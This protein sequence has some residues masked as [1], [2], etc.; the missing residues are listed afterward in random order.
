LT[1]IQLN[2]FF[3]HTFER[4]SVKKYTHKKRSQLMIVIPKCQLLWWVSKVS[5]TIYSWIEQSGYITNSET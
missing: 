4:N 5:P 1:S 2:L 3:G